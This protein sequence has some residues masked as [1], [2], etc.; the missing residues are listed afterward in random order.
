MEFYS[1]IKNKNL[2]FA[3]KWMERENIIFSEV[4][5]VQKHKGCMFFLNV[6]DK[7]NTNLSTV[8]YTYKYVQN[9]S[10][11]AGL[12]ENTKGGVKVEKDGSE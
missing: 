11:K 9:M 3:D 12:L 7:F 1:A 4:S 2:S 5:H 8:I 10:P 6:E